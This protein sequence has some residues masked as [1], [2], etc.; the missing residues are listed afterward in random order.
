MFTTGDGPINSRVCAERVFRGEWKEE[1]GSRKQADQRS[2]AVSVSVVTAGSNADIHTALDAE[3][4]EE[5]GGS[6]DAGDSHR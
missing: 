5:E 4:E 2:G 1:A 3:E 6:V